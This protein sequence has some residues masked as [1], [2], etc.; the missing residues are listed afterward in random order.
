MITHKVLSHRST[1]RWPAFKPNGKQ[2]VRERAVKE[3]T[4]R[5]SKKLEKG[6][7]QHMHTVHWRD[8]FVFVYHEWALLWRWGDEKLRKAQVLN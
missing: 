1:I 6:R 2:S 7:T 3:A 5:R 8:Y 4:S